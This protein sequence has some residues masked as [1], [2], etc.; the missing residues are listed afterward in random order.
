MSE[1]KKEGPWKETIAELLAMGGEMDE[2][3]I[4]ATRQN[5]E[6]LKDTIV[7]HFEDQDLGWAPLSPRYAAKKK[8]RGRSAILI[9]S[10]TLLQSVNYE[11]SADG[12]EAIVGV[13]RKA[14]K[15]GADAVLVGAVMEYG[16]GARNI[17]ARPFLKPSFQEKEDAMRQNYIKKINAVLQNAASKAGGEVE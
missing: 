9:D 1:S 15:K 17:P 8:K 11:I 5:A 6:M 4:L 13:N 7:G 16:S 10:G 2:A 12:K 14:G 3:L